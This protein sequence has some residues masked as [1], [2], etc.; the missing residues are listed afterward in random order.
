MRA[1][2]AGL[3]TT[4]FCDELCRRRRPNS[5]LLTDDDISAHHCSMGQCNVSI[6]REPEISVAKFS[7]RSTT[8][9][10][11]RTM[12]I[13]FGSRTERH[14]TVAAHGV[15][16]AA[17]HEETSSSCCLACRG[18]L[19][20][21]VN[22]SQNHYC[23]HGKH[24]AGWFPSNK[25]HVMHACPHLCCKYIPLM[26]HE[27]LA[28]TRIVTLKKIIEH[29]LTITEIHIIAPAKQEHSKF[30]KLMLHLHSLFLYSNLILINNIRFHI[31]C[32]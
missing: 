20:P 28:Y 14:A 15:H 32:F 11:V 5:P 21:H 27:E 10:D 13:R 26:L 23:R 4:V 9:P 6:D 19:C 18:S 31:D 2:S 1:P 8:R 24:V 12:S 30:R 17:E 29:Y 7:C 25:F 22:L 3:L 16:V